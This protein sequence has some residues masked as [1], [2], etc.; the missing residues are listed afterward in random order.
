M[1]TYSFSPDE[2]SDMKQFY[3]NEYQIKLRELSHIKSMLDKL[4]VNTNQSVDAPLSFNFPSSSKLTSL[5]TPN[6]IKPRSP[7][8]GKRGRKSLWGNFILNQLEEQQKPLSYSEIIQIAVTKF[9]LPNHKL[10]NIKQAITNSAFRLRVIN[11]TIDTV[12]LPGRKEKFLCL[13][14]WFNNGQLKPEYKKYL[15]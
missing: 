14:S 3:S 8:P 9:N 1:N 10:K 2:I 4:G 5:L 13:I 7:K 6:Q 15:R 11:G 12:G